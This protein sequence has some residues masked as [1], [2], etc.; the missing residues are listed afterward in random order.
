MRNIKLATYA[1]RCI[2][3]EILMH[4]RSNKKHTNNISLNDSIGTDKDGNDISLIEVLKSDNIDI[5]EEL[6]QKHN[7]ELLYK[8]IEILSPREKEIVIKRYGLYNNKQ[9]TQKKIAKE[10]DISR[11]YVSRIEKRAIT[12]IL[13]EFIRNK[14]TL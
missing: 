4:Y 10:L 6:N 9:L 1:S 12:K 11:S 8:Y 5:I 2:E 3:N 7:V 14:K 13:R